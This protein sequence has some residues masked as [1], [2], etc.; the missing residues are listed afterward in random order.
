[1]KSLSAIGAV[2]L[3]FSSALP[4]AASCTQAELAGKWTAY[5]VSQPGSS[6]AWT[7]CQLTISAAGTFG[8]ATSACINSANTSA[9]AKGSLKLQNAAQ[10]VFAGTINFPAYDVTDTVRSVTLM[11]NKQEATRIGGGGADGSAF[12]FNMA[13]LQ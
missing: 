8:I 7:T 6:L 1:V 3:A 13:K 4:A 5:S 10:C 9:K 2:A 11:I 12:V